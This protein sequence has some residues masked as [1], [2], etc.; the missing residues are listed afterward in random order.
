MENKIGS[1]SRPAAYSP[2]DIHGTQKTGMT[3]ERKKKLEELIISKRNVSSSSA[4]TGS[5]MTPERRAELEKLIIS[6]RGQPQ[7]AT[8]A[9]RFQQIVDER[10]PEQ[11]Q[12]T[13]LGRIGDAMKKEAPKAITKTLG[14]ML[15]GPLGGIV[16][17]N[18]DTLS[19]DPLK[20]MPANLLEAGKAR[21]SNIME[22]RERQLEGT[23]GTART[24]FQIGG[25]YVAGVNDMLFEG[26]AT[27]AKMVDQEAV[28]HFTE[29]LGKGVRAIGADKAMAKYTTWAEANPALAADIEAAINILDIIPIAKIGT[30]PAKIGRELG[31]S[32]IEAGIKRTGQK[33]VGEM[34]DFIPNPNTIPKNVI[35]E[36]TGL[37]PIQEITEGMQKSAEGIQQSNIIQGGRQMLGDVA[38]A[39]PRAKKRLGRTFEEAAERSKRMDAS[40][41]EVREAIESGV[42]NKIINAVTD[43]DDITRRQ[44]MDMVS[45]ADDTLPDVKHYEEPSIISG[46]SAVDQYSLADTERKR[47]GAQIGDIADSL[48]KTTLVDMD[49]LRDRVMPML[50]GIGVD[51]IDEGKLVFNKAR[52][53]ITK[54]QIEDVQKLYDIINDVSIS[55]TPSNIH[56]KDKVMS[57]L[58]RDRRI[59]GLSD[60]LVKTDEGLT[61]IYDAFRNTFKQTLD[62][63]SPEI[64]VL[65]GEYRTYKNLEE[66]LE[67]T[68]LKIPNYIKTSN[69][70]EFAQTNLRRVMT[71]AT[72]A[73]AYKEIAE[74]LDMIARKLGYQ[75]ASPVELAKFAERLKDIY[76]D[77]I[78]E[79]SFR[80][81]ISKGVTGKALDL[82][83]KVAEY[84]KAGVY[85]QQRALRRLLG[86]DKEMSSAVKDV[87]KPSLSA[88]SKK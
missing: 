10:A 32:A 84:G 76:P 22:A 79:A 24:S 41:P 58:G 28:E 64:R 47:I 1:V 46:N 31:E 51:S 70:A 50:K 30:A 37:K 21:G 57:T 33:V 49:Q 12:Q 68:I 78:R 62:D 20:E 5:S 44:Q 52:T 69:P 66:M 23:Q 16:A 11:P 4:N 35:P 14:S 6:K 72:S 39:F 18:L 60:I 77:T 65:N 36:S 63:I 61:S 29:A 48:S 2:A 17:S 13:G 15:G 71:N 9:D 59:E 7:Q 54:T 56:I 87:S 34:V 74:E 73:A 80:G 85:D 55:P 38:A 82:G 40:T 83:Q 25:Q 27:G 26:L 81:G 42:N 75:G 67:K 86:L 3:P 8:N 88:F 19:L 43:A 53:E 45:I